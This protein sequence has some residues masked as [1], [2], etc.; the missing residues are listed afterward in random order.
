MAPNTKIK[1]HTINVHLDGMIVGP[2]SQTGRPSDNWVITY[3]TSEGTHETVKIQWAVFTTFHVIAKISED[4]VLLGVHL[5]CIDDLNW[6]SYRS[7]AF[8]Y[9]IGGGKPRIRVEWN[10]DSALLETILRNPK[11]EYHYANPFEVAW[12]IR[13][14]DLP[15]FCWESLE[16]TL[17]K[18]LSDLRVHHPPD[19]RVA[20]WVASRKPF[21]SLKTLKAR[22]VGV[23]KRL[24]EAGAD[25]ETIEA[26][27]VFKV[28]AGGNFRWGS[29][30]RVHGVNRGPGLS[31]VFSDLTLKTILMSTKDLF[32]KSINQ[33]SSQSSGRMAGY[34]KQFMT[35]AVFC[36]VAYDKV[37]VGD[38]V[39][40]IWC[41]FLELLPD[42]IDKYL[43]EYIT[44]AIKSVASLASLYFD[45][46]PLRVNR[47][48]ANTNA[49]IIEVC[50]T[51]RVDGRFEFCDSWV[52]LVGDG[53]LLMLTLLPHLKDY[54]FEQRALTI[55]QHWR[56][57]EI[58]AWDQRQLTIAS[59]PVQ[60]KP[61]S[62]L[63]KPRRRLL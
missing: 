16:A 33:Y 17:P 47:Q 58:R 54:S 53:S 44:D 56:N 60:G 26:L 49:P 15:A 22:M 14:P 57:I 59:T 13:V 25:S 50:P 11:F 29:N 42:S 10:L 32:S 51:T 19:S 23:E 3:P 35:L 2:E 55:G 61:S 4:T 30:T 28:W 7:K 8:T 36:A 5:L 52:S 41:R 21:Q 43:P 48:G 18:T 31:N 63:K 9:G 27:C 62:P 20:L 39:V 1:A 37:K 24:M 40:S 34:L 6:I 12:K 46:S 45:D 38:R